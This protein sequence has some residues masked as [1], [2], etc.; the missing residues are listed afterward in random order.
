MANFIV[1]I[2]S[3][4]L[5]VVVLAGVFIST[6][7]TTNTTGWAAGEIALWGMLTIASI[8]GLVFGVMNVFG[9]A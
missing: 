5:G 3:L 8:S 1:G 4:T 6:V 2:I 9:L 7:K